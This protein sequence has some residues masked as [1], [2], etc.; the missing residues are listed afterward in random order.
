[1]A[2]ATKSKELFHA[3]KEGR[4][5]LAPCRKY[6]TCRAKTQPMWELANNFLSEIENLPLTFCGKYTF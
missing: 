3:C 5:M 2:N 1:M 4:R 6:R